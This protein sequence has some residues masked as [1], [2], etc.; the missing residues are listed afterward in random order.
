MTAL[1]EEAFT[2]ASLLSEPE[3]DALVP[4]ILEE[5]EAEHRWGKS[6]ARSLDILHQLA[7]EALVGHRTT[8]TSVLC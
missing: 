1:L 6:F 5:I 3:Q 7:N 4:W 2:Q 8:P